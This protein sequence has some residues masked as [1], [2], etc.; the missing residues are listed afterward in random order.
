MS[1]VLVA[2]ASKYGSTKEVAE[3]V[4]A[5]IREK[6]ESVDIKTVEDI[7]SVDEYD[8]IVLGAALYAGN[9]SRAA[10]KFLNRNQ[11]GLAAKPVSMFVLGPIGPDEAE[12]TGAKEQLAKLLEKYEWL[13]PVATE[14]FIGKFDATMLK[15][16]VTILLK[17]P[18]SPL[19]GMTQQ[20]NR[21]WNAISAWATN[22]R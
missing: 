11:A 14:V 17:L 8:K 12:M 16:P 3:K 21:D 7:N 20:D 2:Y 19:Y 9:L 13:K 1:K 4:G 15:F 6:G 22:V 18:A 10:R 5:V